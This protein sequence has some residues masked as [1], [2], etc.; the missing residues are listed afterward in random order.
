[1]RPRVPNDCADF[2][3]A[4][5]PA[6]VQITAPGADP[7]P[8]DHLRL[9]GV[10]FRLVGELRLVA[11]RSVWL[12][13]ANTYYRMPKEE[14]IREQDYSIDRRVDDGR[15]HSCRRMW[16]WI[17]EGTWLRARIPASCQAGGR[18][19]HLPGCIL[20][21]GGTWDEVANGASAE[22]CDE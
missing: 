9:D 10:E 16:F 22:A 5:N 11:E 4:L 19:R 18:R 12:L 14:C 1:M 15:W 3:K 17:D 13:H 8:V 2:R 21:I 6:P 20:A 7:Q